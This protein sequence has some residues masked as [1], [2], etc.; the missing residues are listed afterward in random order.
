MWLDWGLGS[1]GFGRGLVRERGGEGD[2]LS[3]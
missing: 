1:D 2:A 3:T